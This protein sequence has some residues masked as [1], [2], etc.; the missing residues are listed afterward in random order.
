MKSETVAIM[1][2]GHMGHAIGGHLARAGL[3]VI[4]NLEGRSTETRAR[5]ERAGIEDVGSDVRLVDEADILLSVLPPANAVTLARRAAEAI[6][7]ADTKLLY[8]DCNA[9]SPATAA[10]VAEILGAVGVNCVDASIRGGAPLGNK[11]Q[12]RIYASGPGAEDFQALN[13]YGLD[14][15]PIGSRAGQASGLKICG[16]SISKGIVLLFVQAFAAAKAMG[17]EKE[18]REDI[19]S[20]SAFRNAE[21]R[22]PNL[23]PDAYRWASEM[24]EIAE[25]FAAAGLSPKTFEGFADLC[26][27]VEATPMGRQTKENISLGTDL[28]EIADILVTALKDK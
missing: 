9:I 12:P 11:P 27:L 4:T 5:A 8:V 25:T 2:P 18:L 17:I 13:R 1:A 20:H 7:A 10:E 23:G 28:D 16:A 6:E 26:R 3:K 19:G 21:R 24:D 14:I 15:H 22:S